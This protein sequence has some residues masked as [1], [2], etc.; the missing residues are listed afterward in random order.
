[1]TQTRPAPYPAGKSV[2]LD[3]SCIYS[4]APSTNPE[5]NTATAAW[6]NA[7]IGAPDSSKQGTAGVDFTSVIP[8]KV[9]QTVTV[10]D[11]F[12]GTTTTL[13]TLTATDSAPFT[14]HTY[15]YSHTLSV[16]TNG[17]CTTFKNTA[18]IVVGTTIIQASA[19]VD[20]RVCGSGKTGALTMCFWQNK[21]GQ[22]IIAGSGPSSGTCKLTTWL[23]TFAP[24]QDLSAT[25][26]CG[27]V[28]STNTKYT[29]VVTTS[30]TAYVASVIYFAEAGG[31]SMNPMLK[32]QMLATALDVYFSDPTLGG[33]KI[34]A[35]NGLGNSQ[36]PIGGI[37]IDL[38]KVCTMI[39][40]SNGT[41]TCSGTYQNDSSA[42]GGATSMTVL[43]MLL[44]QNNVSTVGGSIWYGQV[45]TTQGLAKNAFDA[46]NS[47]VAFTL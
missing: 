6:D 34:G 30:A 41:A 28:Q 10:N 22:G 5:T 39:D 45:K 14:T 21:N 37:T 9:N 27:T 7:S 11:T 13:G 17:V 16:P 43:N 35:F 47:G 26:P 29:S 24:F 3:Y 18:T 23:R 19:E 12:Q 2:T 40:S 1:M 44:Y 8:T 15:T 31:P 32:A 42:F 4:A 38:T 25:A 33:N 46:I 36:P 20:V